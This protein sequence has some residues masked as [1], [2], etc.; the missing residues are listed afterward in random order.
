[1][2][3]RLE[4]KEYWKK[5]GSD[6]DESEGV[7]CLIKGTSTTTIGAEEDVSVLIV[8]D[9]PFLFNV[10]TLPVDTELLDFLFAR[11]RA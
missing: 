5:R 8:S 1:L 9:D 4:T 11:F 3:L 7:Q 6:S 2:L 10:T